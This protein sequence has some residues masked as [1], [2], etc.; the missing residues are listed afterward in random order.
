MCICPLRDQQRLMFVS[1]Q[2]EDGPGSSGHP[3][4]PPPDQQRLIFASKQLGDGPG[5]SVRPYMFPPDQQRLIFSDKHGPG[6]SGHPYTPPRLLTSNVLSS[7]AS[8]SRMNWRVWA[9][10]IRPLLTSNVSS[11]PA[12]SSRMDQGVRVC[13]YAPS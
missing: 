3:Y 6:S 2:L 4:M 8:S 13:V 12:S 7:L 1:K 10:H 9:V 5:S 11:S